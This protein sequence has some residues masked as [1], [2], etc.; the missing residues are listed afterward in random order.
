MMGIQRFDAKGQLIREYNNLRVFF[1]RCNSLA[2]KWLLSIEAEALVPDYP[3]RWSS[4]T[5]AIDM[6][7]GPVPYEWERW[8]V[9]YQSRELLEEMLVKRAIFTRPSSEEL[10]TEL[11]ALDNFIGTG[12]FDPRFPKPQIS[13]RPK[14]TVYTARWAPPITLPEVTLMDSAIR[15]MQHLQALWMRWYG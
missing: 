8:K 14:Q 12:E 1:Q 2:Y 7:W 11:V 13:S 9:D 4:F 6:A 5:A 15:R 3:L 10:S